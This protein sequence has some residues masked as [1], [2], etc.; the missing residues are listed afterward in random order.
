MDELK[1]LIEQAGVPYL[2][3][4]DL[5]H[6]HASLLIDK[7]FSAIEVASRLGHSDTTTTLRTYVQSFNKQLERKVLSMD[8]LTS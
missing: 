4:H 8:D 5:R 1:R 6:A 3:F 2:R 7:G